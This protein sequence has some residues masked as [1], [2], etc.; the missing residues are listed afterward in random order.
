MILSMLLR[1]GQVR[2]CELEQALGIPH[3][4]V[5]N[6]QRQLAEHGA[7][8]FFRTRGSRGG[9][10]MTPEVVAACE[11]DLAA[12]LSVAQVAERNDVA[13]GTLEKA[14]SQK[15]VRRVRPV[16]A[17]T[18]RDEAS[19]KAERSRE[20]AECKLGTA[21]SRPAERLL[22]AMGALEH[23][24]SRYERCNDVAFGGVLAGLPALD[25]NGLFHR[26]Q[27]FYR[28]PKG[29]YG[30]VQLFM[31]FGL[32][33]LARIQRLEG[34]RYVPPGELGKLLGLDRVPEVKT[35]RRKIAAL[36]EQDADG[37][38][39]KALCGKWME[40]DPEEAGY[41]YVDGHVRVYHGAL[42]E[43]PKRYVTRE[44]LCLRG[45]TDYW[46]ND[47][48]GRP[49]FVV[50]KTISD[51]L[52]KTLLEEIVPQL[53]AT[54]PA[55]PS[56]EELEADPQLH[57]FAIVFD[58]EGSNATLI[59]ALWENRISAITYRKNVKDEWP[60]AQFAAHTVHLPMGNAEEMLL[61]ERPTT[62]GTG[63]ATLAVREVRKLSAGGR[64]T[65]IITTLQKGNLT[66]IAA[67]MFTRWCQ[68]NYFSYAKQHFEL[69][70]LVE[71][72]TAE[73]PGTTTVINPAWRTLEKT[74]KSA[75]AALVRKT[76]KF[77]QLQLPDESPPKNTE[78]E[79]LARAKILEE[80]NA[81]QA[82]LDELKARRKA[83]PKHILFSQLPEEQKF[84]RL[85]PVRKQFCDTIKMI[86]YRAET[87]L[88]QQLRPHLKRDD[89]A[90]AL[91]RQLFLSSADLIPDEA[92]KCLTVRIHRMAN[93]A[94]D[95]A[96][97]SLLE[98]LNAADFTHP[99]TGHAIRYIMA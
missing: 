84:D 73:I 89:D 10:V 15:R 63:A 32:T 54:V 58:R 61:A 35:A 82:V 87:A 83:T 69:D 50:S 31:F 93:P 60:V 12:G 70:G 4:T 88:V 77:G 16:A 80:I 65:A 42:T 96:V 90:R 40:A 2:S 29:F 18:A 30:L 20:D 33:T 43:L 28:L 78:K 71:Y 7:S 55:Q 68:E 74:V 46:V 79:L 26:I 51:G 24:E 3:R 21:C 97:A 23:A 98:T 49:F 44:R 91:L 67:R 27:E 13:Q 99:E 81:D 17:P 86:A 34:L 76:A 95:Q 75:T 85:A 64:Q 48:I 22:A 47:A 92:A 25:A 1:N 56:T 38:W 11:G 14:M 45:T 8:S 72:G 6:W 59:R 57:R 62:I 19:S 5:M 94:H 9:K 53:L 52:A 36:A 66:E 39:G 41:L 37:Q